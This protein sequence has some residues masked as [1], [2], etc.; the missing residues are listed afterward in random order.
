MDHMTISTLEYDK[1]KENLR[2]YAVSYLGRKH[3]D[4]LMPMTDLSAIESA[5]S[6]TAEAK[7]ILGSGTSIPLPSLEG[8]DH[9]VSLLH[10]GYLFRA[11]DFSAVQ[12]FLH[13]CGQLIRY[14]AGKREIAPL[15]SGYASSMRELEHLRREIERCIRSGRVD[16]QASRKLEK[17]RRKIMT[18]KDRIQRKIS[19]ILS[20]HGTILQENLISMRG[21]RYVIPVKREHQKQVKGAVLDQSNTGQTVFVEPEEI[22]Q[23]QM[24]LGMLEADE[25]REEAVILSMLTELLEEASADLLRNIEITG[26]YDFIFAKAKYGRSI[27]GRKAQFNNR[28]WIRIRGAKHPMML[29]KMVPLELELGKNYRSLIIT[30]PNTGGKTVAL[31]TLG[32]LTLMVQSGLLV[33]VAEGSVFAVFSQV[34]TAIGDGQSIEQSLSTFSAQIR[35]LAA[36]V[37]TAD[38]STLLLIDELAAGTD[39]G[40]GMS[41][42][43]A[44]LE[45]LGHRGAM[46]MVTTHFNELKGFASRAPGFQNAR[47]EFDVESL[48]PLYR[49]T[50]GESGQSYAIE[51]A[52]KL[53]L[54]ESIIERSRDILQVHKPH[55]SG[56]ELN[57]E[58]VSESGMDAENQNEE[59]LGMDMENEIGVDYGMGM[60][61]E[62]GADYGMDTMKTFSSDQNR[63]DQGKQPQPGKGGESVQEPAKQDG[64]LETPESEVEALRKDSKTEVK[65][66]EP[67]RLEVGDTVFVTSLQRVGI[68]YQEVDAKGMIGVMIEKQKLKINHKRVELYTEKGNLLPGRL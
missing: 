1:V 63:S 55:L 61:N 10:T 64:H 14:M 18:V 47:M 34:M 46:M 54:A 24:E 25:A 32:L 13:S 43:I 5:V 52:T 8:I 60:E 41:L 27:E 59:D 44:I 11:Q 17:I 7:E 66:E 16:D 39:P 40:E 53:G 49:L 20:R 9:I 58:P 56:T 37:E 6:E 12:T 62:I 28:G 30:G 50:I 67:R 21:G 4:E 57:H 15:V 68:V 19:S 42:S 23:L 45:E 36:M 51:I 31:K 65:E 2:E 48:A 3:I 33:P 22:A 35:R 26:K 29:N 38:R